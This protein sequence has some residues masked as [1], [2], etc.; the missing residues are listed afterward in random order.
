MPNLQS[1]FD[2]L[3]DVTEPICQAID[4]A[5]ADMAIFDSSGMEAF[6]RE[7]NP[8][9]AISRLFKPRTKT[10]LCQWA[11]LLCVQILL[12]HPIPEICLSKNEMEMGQDNEKILPWNVRSCQP[13]TQN[14]RTLHADLILSGITQ[15]I[16]VVLTDKIHHHEYIQSLKPFTAFA[17]LSLSEYSFLPFQAF[18]SQLPNF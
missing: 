13:R 14:E 4:T 11:F 8:K 10:A 17:D 3:V 1:V 5:K 2:N 12:R 9:Y 18:V 16:T 15:L 6:V 7:N